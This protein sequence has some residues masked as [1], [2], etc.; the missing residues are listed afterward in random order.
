MI[1]EKNT[2]FI[3]TKKFVKTKFSKYYF[4]LFL[5]TLFFVLTIIAVLFLSDKTYGLLNSEKIQRKI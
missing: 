2:K 3:E 1:L 5:A 4:F